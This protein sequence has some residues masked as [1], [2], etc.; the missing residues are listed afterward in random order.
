MLVARGFD[1]RHFHSTRLINIRLARGKPLYNQKSRVSRALVEGHDFMHYV[2]MIKDS[3]EN[4]Y[5]GITE[6]LDNRLY[7][8]NAKQ[9]AQF[10][11]F[12]TEFKLV[13]SEKYKTLADA[14]RREIQIKKWRRN[15]KELLIARY[16]SG[17]PTKLS[18]A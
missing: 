18:G 8:H 6:N 9:G 15:K 14:R 5:V 1:S 4:L 10:T 7:D 17:L 16:S 11:K 12:K 13:F 2:Y 3:L